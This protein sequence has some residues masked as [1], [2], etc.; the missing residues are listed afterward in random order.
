LTIA[1]LSHEGRGVARSAEG[2]TVFVDLALPG[3]TVLAHWLR[4][5][6]RFDEAVAVEIHAP[7]AERVA[8]RCPHFGVCGGC[9]L[10]HLAPAAQIRHKEAVLLEQIQH[11]AGG[12]PTRTLPP[13][14]GPLWGYRGKARLGVK[15]VEKKGGVLVGFRE[16]HAPYVAD[17]SR[18]EVLD[19]RV[20]ERL[21]EIRAALAGL[22][23]AAAIPQIEMAIA[24]DTVA[25]V[26]RHLQPLTDA[27]K[28]H[29][30]A[31]AARCG[32]TFFLQP[33]GPD[34]ILPLDPATPAELTY[35]L[36]DAWGPE[37]GGA[38]PGAPDEV[39]AAGGAAA[40]GAG[41]GL[42]FTHRPT[43]FTQINQEINRA[44]VRRAVELLAPA[45]GERILDLFAGLGNFTLPLAQRGAEVLGIEGDPGLV[46][47]A[48]ANAAANGLSARARFLAADLSLGLPPLPDG[49]A[50]GP[51]GG[52]AGGPYRKLLLDPPRC[53]AEE[54]LRA[55]PPTPF[56]RIVYVSCNPA[57]LARDIGYLLRERGY[58]LC[59][60][61]VMDMFPHTAHVESMAVLEPAP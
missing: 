51:A 3:E 32:F 30:A 60:A 25:L 39:P 44:M 13:L 40:G 53:G 9:S 24:D 7:S 45:P 48:T 28:G 55:L 50:D 27:D 23:V 16:R 6:G 37:A 15:W 22:S 54:V 19:P 34:S 31:L 14:T 41:A 49:P 36:A 38:G 5:H 4:R 59:A 35:T 17:L 1:A 47:R 20:G 52:P 46:A 2:K 43:D 33:K 10:Q 29:L 56:A 18:C 21:P 26:I 58:R 42:R 8:P 61:G 12:A 57:T 11:A